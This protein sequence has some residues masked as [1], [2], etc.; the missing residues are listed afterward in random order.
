MVHLDLPFLSVTTTGDGSSGREPLSARSINLPSWE[1]RW[2]SNTGF[3][4]CRNMKA[5][6]TRRPSPHSAATTEKA[7]RCGDAGSL[8]P[9]RGTSDGKLGEGSG[10]S[11]KGWKLCRGD[12]S[13]ER[14]AIED[15]DDDFRRLDIA[16]GQPYSASSGSKP[17]C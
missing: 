9:C 3:L 1:R 10:G 13:I 15:I 17:S 5:N 6:Q 7:V 12:V 8:L 14:E 11:S 2:I 16:D 4:D